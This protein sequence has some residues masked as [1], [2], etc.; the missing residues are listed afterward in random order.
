MPFSLRPHPR[1]KSAFD[2]L[3]AFIGIAPTGGAHLSRRTHE[4]YRALLEKKHG[5]R[6]PR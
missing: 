5:V 4:K 1:A 2:R 3:R 6:R